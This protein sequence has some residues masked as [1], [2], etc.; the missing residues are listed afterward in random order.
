MRDVSLPNGAF[1]SGCGACSNACSKGAIQMVADSEGFLYPHID[2]ALC[3]GCGACTK[4]CPAGKIKQPDTAPKAYYAWSKNEEIRKQS[5]SGGV[6]THLAE[7]ILSQGGVVVG[8]I[9]DENLVVRHAVIFSTDELCKLRTSKYVQS[10]TGDVYRQTKAALKSG[11]PVLFTGTPCQIAALKQYLSMDYENL[12]LQ[13]IICHGVPSPGIWQEYLYQTRDGKD[14]ETVSFRDKTESW[15]RF[16]L[17]ISYKDGSSFRECYTDN[18]YMKA[19]LANL[20]LR[21]SCYQCQYRGIGRVSDITLAD[22][23]GVYTVHPELPG[24]DGISLVLTHSEKGER[25]LTGIRN[26]IIGG[27]TDFAQAVSLNP[28]YTHSV[29]KPKGR[30]AFFQKSKKLPFSKLVAKYSRPPL[31]K[32]IYRSCKS[33]IQKEKP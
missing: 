1:C 25:L 20:S 8:A 9:M 31:W 22:Y 18:D 15:Y 12:Y 14:V 17:A 27:E 29:K 3:V 19:F 33:I 23:W 30:S 2:E 21:P 28:P 24:K 16:S 5:S 11:K 32:R 10:D 6:F 13:D 26:E 7:Y 4:T